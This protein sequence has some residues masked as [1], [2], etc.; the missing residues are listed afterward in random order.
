V[1]DHVLTV[2]AVCQGFALVRTLRRVEGRAYALCLVA[3]LGITFAALVQ[4]SRFLGVV[5]IALSVALLAVPL[6]LEAL[7][8]WGFARGKLGIAVALCGVRA[9]LM[10]GAGLG[11]SPTSASSRPMP[12]VAS[13]SSSTNRSCR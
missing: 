8:R 12:K 9:M 4:P 1:F 7:A 11:R 6:V 5:A 2:C 13:R 3:L 10:P